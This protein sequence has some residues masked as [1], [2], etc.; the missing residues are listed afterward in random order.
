LCH[1]RTGHGDDREREQIP[2]RIHQDLPDAFFVLAALLVPARAR[3]R[4]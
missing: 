3:M 4:A 1:G 2:R